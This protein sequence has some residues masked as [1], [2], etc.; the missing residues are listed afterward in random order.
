[1]ATRT[2]IEGKWNEAKGRIREAWGDLTDDDLDRTRGS[3]EQIVG[4]IRQ[5]TG[6]GM[7]QVETSLNE[8]LDGLLEPQDEAS[9]ETAS[10]ARH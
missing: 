3:W 7:N 6:Q 8:L 2:I 4:V 10:S 1:M 5:K 9:P